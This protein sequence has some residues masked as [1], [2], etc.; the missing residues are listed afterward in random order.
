ME[1]ARMKRRAQ[2]VTLIA[3]LITALYV[4][5]YVCFRAA[6]VERWERDGRGHLIFPANNLTWYYVYR[7][8]SYVDGRL[9]DMRFHIGSH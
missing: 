5:S 3:L 7:P 4:G 6:H 9:T 8:A 2:Y 1:P